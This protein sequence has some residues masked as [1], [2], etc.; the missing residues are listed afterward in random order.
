[1]EETEM[2]EEDTLIPV[3]D[4]LK[5]GVHIGTQHKTNDMEDFIYKVRD[6]GLYIFDIGKT[7]QRIRTAAR[8]LSRFD[9]SKILAVSA[10]EYGKRPAELFAKIVGGKSSVGRMIPGMLTNPNL[11]HYIEP[12]IVVATD[13]I[14]DQQALKEANTSG[15]PVIA[16]CDTNNMISNVD[17]VIPA[18][19]KGRKA[20]SMV[21]WL[22]SRETVKEQERLADDEKFKYEVEDFEA[23]I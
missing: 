20:L 14:G 7:D 13:P 19:N 8:F 18:N 5:A 12:E 17:L 11:D 1:M 4:Y 22:L 3:E 10:R 21:Y 2:V 23:E 16:L 6:D 15:I 9:P